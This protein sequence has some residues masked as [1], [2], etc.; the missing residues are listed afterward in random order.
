MKYKVGER[1]VFGLGPGSVLEADEVLGLKGYDLNALVE[2]GHLEVVDDETPVGPA[3]K[4]KPD[5]KKAV[6]P[7]PKPAEESK[8]DV[9]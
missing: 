1:E 2:S 8:E 5:V 4:A 3:P 6:A 9:K 7:K